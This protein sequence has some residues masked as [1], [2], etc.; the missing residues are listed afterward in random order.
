MLLIICVSLLTI[1]VYGSPAV[2]QNHL[3]EIALQPKNGHQPNGPS[4]LRA[5]FFPELY[6]SFQESNVDLDCASNTVLRISTQKCSCKT[7][8]CPERNIQNRLR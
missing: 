3:I 6:K 4:K 7:Y 2:I 8:L 5:L 1:T